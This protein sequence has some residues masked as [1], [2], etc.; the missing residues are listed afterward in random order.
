MICFFAVLQFAIRLLA[1][2]SNDF[3]EN[4]SQRDQAGNSQAAVLSWTVNCGLWT[5]N[6]TLDCLPFLHFP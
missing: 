5:E 2:R 3:C 1:I 6:W 4:R